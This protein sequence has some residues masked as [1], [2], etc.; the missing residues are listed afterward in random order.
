VADYQRVARRDHTTGEWGDVVLAEGARRPVRGG[1]RMWG[2]IPHWSHRQ[3]VD[4]ADFG[5]GQQRPRRF[6]PGFQR[7]FVDPPGRVRVALDLHVLGE[8]TVTDG[9]PEC[10]SSSTWCGSSALPSIAVEW[11]ASRT[12]MSSQIPTASAGAGSPPRRCRSSAT[13]ASKRA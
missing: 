13:P 4:V 3:P 1:V 8:L 9:T 6:V 11:C 2:D 7:L 5:D 12:Q 10:S